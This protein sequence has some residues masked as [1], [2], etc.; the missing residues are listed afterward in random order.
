MSIVTAEACTVESDHRQIPCVMLIGRGED[1]KRLKRRVPFYP[2]FYLLEEDYKALKAAKFFDQMHVVAVEG[3][4]TRSIMKRLLTKITVEDGGRIGDSI[5]MVNKASK[6]KTLGFNALDD[7]T[8]FTYEA[9]LGKSDLLPLRWMVDNEIKCGVEITGNTY[10]PIDFSVALRKWYLDF[11]AYTLR[12]YTSGMN[13]EDYL[14]MVSVYDSYNQTM[15]TYYVINE[16]WKP[17]LQLQAQAKADIFLSKSQCPKHVIK[18]FKSESQFLDAL[19][20]LKVELDPDVMIAWNLNRYDIEKWKQRVDANGKKCLHLFRDISPM[21][22]VLWHS[23]PH[24]VKGMVLFDLMV[25]FKQFTDAELDAYSL[26]FVTEK[27]HLGV[28]KI[29]F[30]GS[31]GNTW[32]NYPETMFRRNVA[33]VLI[34]KALDDKYGLVETYDESRK[35]FG[36]LWHESFVR[37]R[38]IDSALLRMTHGKVVLGTPRYGQDTGEKLKGAIVIEP[39]LGDN[40]WIAG[41]DLSR[42]YPSIIKGFNISPET[43][44][45]TEPKAPHYTL[46]YSWKDANG[47]TKDFTAYFLK[48]PTGLLPQLILTFDAMRTRYQKEMSKAIANHEPESVIKKWERRQYNIKKTTNAIYGVMDFA[49][50]RL[51][52][53]ECTQAV[54]I[55]GRITIEE[56]VRYLDTI[57]YSLL[58]GDTDST[59]V[60]LHSSTPEECLKEAQE[61]QKNVNDHLTAFFLEKYGATAHA[62][63]GLKAVYK[64]V[65]FL[66]KKL[67]AGKV[68]WDE[69]KSWIANDSDD[70][71]DIKG[72]SS[73]RSDASALEKIAVKEVLKMSLDDKEDQIEAYKVELLKDF[74]ARAYG[75]M[76]IAYP[77]QLKDRMWNDPKKGWCT[78][79]AGLDKNGR[80][81]FPSHARSAIYDNMFLNTDFT[82]GDKPRR[83]PIKFLKVSKVS[84]TQTTLFGQKLPQPKYPSEW[85][86]RGR[87]NGIKADVVIP[88]KDISIVEDFRIPDYFLDLIDWDRIRKRLVNKLNKLSDPSIEV[89][90]EEDCQLVNVE[91]NSSV[92]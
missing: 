64:K 5:H 16:H 13:Q 24:R 44:R 2:Y 25:A 89:R 12:E 62:E 28:E 11:E 29:P 48:Q 80:L 18:S 90:D 41:L 73:V 39:K 36:C 81:S 66:A 50:F 4:P 76:D 70:S 42:D 3:S 88:V 43:Y 58:Y 57:K 21:L 47:V 75:P 84:K 72:V 85:I 56:M 61:L 10:K 59:F 27:E 63:L 38:V 91:E 17:S 55:L 60:Q 86:Y 67:Y 65:R 1:L 35:E 19:M 33:D 71:Y 26:G 78:D 92:Q 30:T 8:I 14:I 37:N 15:Y 32:D 20:D 82:E 51:M 7:R 77:M 23:R 83:L 6:Q 34:M 79:A 68:L 52:R 54:A 9:D 49:G 74:D 69:K 40:Y 31:S 22:S 53:K 45:E 87:T 46:H